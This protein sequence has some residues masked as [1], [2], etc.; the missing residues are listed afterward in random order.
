MTTSYCL[1][2]L[3]ALKLCLCHFFLTVFKHAVLA[4]RKH[5]VSI[6]KSNQ[7]MLFREVTAVYIENHTKDFNMLCG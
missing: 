1:T 7:L 3:G 4:H 2:A 6:T 5:H